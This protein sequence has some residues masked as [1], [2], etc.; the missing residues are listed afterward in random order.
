MKPNYWVIRWNKKVNGEELSSRL[1]QTFFDR[2]NPFETYGYNNE[3]DSKFSK[4]KQGDQVFC[5]QSDCFVSEEGKFLA[6]CKVKWITRK[7]PGGRCLVLEKPETLDYMVMNFTRTNTLLRLRRG[8]PIA[9]DLLKYLET[10][11]KPLYDK[12]IKDLP[13]RKSR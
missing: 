6:V 5:F 9:D 1:F 10:H 13:T 12:M 11:S 3:S 4:V 8:Y 2:P 7:S